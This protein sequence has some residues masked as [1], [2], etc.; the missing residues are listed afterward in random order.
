MADRNCCVCDRSLGEKEGQLLTLTEAEK[1]YI[2]TATREEA[3]SDLIYCKPCYRILSDRNAGA[4]LLV[5]TLKNTLRAWGSHGA[6]KAAKEY[7]TFLLGKAA[8][9]RVS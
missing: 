7:E 9:T 8:K 3:P 6:D 2:K 4:Q 1:E 5:G